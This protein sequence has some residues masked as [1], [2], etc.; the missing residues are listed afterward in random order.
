MSDLIQKIESLAKAMEAGSYDAAPST[1]TQGAAQQVEDLSPIMHNLTV[2]EDAFK[3]QKMIGDVESCKST[4]YSFTRQLSFGSFGGS[5]Q[6][7]GQV[8][9]ED[10]S[11]FARVS[12]PM[13]YYSHVRV[14]TDAAGMVATVDGKKMDE[15]AAA[16][17]ARKIACDVEFDL[18]RGCDDYSNVGVFDGN[19]LAVAPM[20]NLNGIG[21]QVRQSDFQA[22]ARDAMF[23]E[24]GSG[25]SCVIS[26]G[27]LAL[28]QDRVED[29]AVRSSLNFGNASRLLVDP[30]ALSLY[31]RQVF[32][33]ERIILAGSPQDATGGDLRKQWVSGGTVNIEASHFLRGKSKTARPRPNGPAAP[34][35]AGANAAGGALA[36]GA[37]VYYV[38]S[39]NEFG[40][41]LPSAA[42]TVTALANE[43]VA[44]TITHPVSGTVARGFNVYRSAA[45]GT[46]ASAKFIGR[47]MISNSS[48][49]VFT[50]LGNRIPGFVTGFLLQEDAFQIRELS[51]YSRAKLAKT[52]LANRE[53][54][55]RFL[56]LA[57]TAPRKNALIENLKGEL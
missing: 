5:A 48:T 14:V 9:S 32:G 6:L 57:V 54:H 40:E 11:D 37:Y 43:K 20:A 1:L 19:P 53:A 27:G 10:N 49:T 26:G 28:A 2:S 41:S 33:K 24:Y 4:T 23:Q 22:N 52:D 17:A 44:L 50:D 12:V 51:P 46:A 42:A 16:D 25:D 7:E 56:T 45:G 8:G 35:F 47:V 29:A 21:L 18:L 34:T 38:S 15:R 39:F 3:V 55:F 36:A 31:N 13:S 30:V